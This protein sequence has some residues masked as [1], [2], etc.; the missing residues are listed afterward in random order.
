M[1]DLEALKA[2]KGRED[3]MIREIE[4]LRREYE[5]KLEELKSSLSEELA[6]A[7]ERLKNKFQSDIEQVREETQKKADII[8]EESRAKANNMK[9]K[10]SD[11]D[12]EK[13]VNDSVSEFLGSL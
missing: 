3:S 2:I 11:E 6:A 5:K 9:I 10:I 7:E 1:E 8:I 12:I 4:E 13:Y